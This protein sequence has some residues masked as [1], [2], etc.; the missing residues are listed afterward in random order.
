MKNTEKVLWITVFF[1]VLTLM[2]SFEA[3]AAPE[4][5]MANVHE[6]E[7]SKV[8][9]YSHMRPP[10]GFGFNNY[11]V[12]ADMRVG[13]YPGG[14]DKAGKLSGI[15]PPNVM[16]LTINETAYAAEIVDNYIN[17]SGDNLSN[18]TLKAAQVAFL[19]GEKKLAD[20]FLIPGKPFNPVV[21]FT[22]DLNSGKVVRKSMTPESNF[23]MK[24]RQDVSEVRDAFMLINNNPEIRRNFESMKF[25]RIPHMQPYNGNKYHVTFMPVNFCEIMGPGMPPHPPEFDETQNITGVD[26][27]VSIKDRRILG[28]SVGKMFLKKNL[29][30]MHS[31]KLC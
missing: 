22:V 14:M 19:M 13:A 21:K 6:A 23:F 30:R 17:S 15:N 12:G 26:V 9:L 27:N 3:F 31:R 10:G 20:V 5:N 25:K 8:G 1:G 24:S 18:Y 28:F 4:G 7:S 29:E 11:F 2:P 16:N